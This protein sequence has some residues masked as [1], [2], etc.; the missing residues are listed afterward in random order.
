M[1][2]IMRHVV[3]WTKQHPL[4]TL[5]PGLLF[6]Y[7]PVV[8]FIMNTERNLGIVVSI[9]LG[10]LNFFLFTRG[11]PLV[12]AILLAATGFLFGC[13]FEVLWQWN[14]WMRLLILGVLMLNSAGWV[15]FLTFLSNVSD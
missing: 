9:P 12:P 7:A 14:R 6:A 8:Q 4:P 1:T 3:T 2:S 10:L 5:I 13:I 15:C 11:T